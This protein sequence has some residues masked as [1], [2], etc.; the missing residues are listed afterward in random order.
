[1]MQLFDDSPPFGAARLAAEVLIQ[2]AQPLSPREE[3]PDATVQVDQVAH[4]ERGIDL[5]P[6]AEVLEVEEINCQLRSVR[7][8]HQV[9]FLQ[10][11]RVTTSLVQLADG[12]GETLGKPSPPIEIAAIGQREAA[13][14]TR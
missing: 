1:M 7:F 6:P 2:E 11:M 3:A 9:G 14:N 8:H 13:W 5:A 4:S 10:I 12:S